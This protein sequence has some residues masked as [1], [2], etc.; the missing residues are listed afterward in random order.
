MRQ[1]SFFDT[2]WL[3]WLHQ[4]LRS[5]LVVDNKKSV[6]ISLWGGNSPYR[7]E[8]RLA[9]ATECRGNSKPNDTLIAY[10]QV[11]GKKVMGFADVNHPARRRPRKIIG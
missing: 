10:V 2:R 5:F 11:V 1:T 7:Y 3:Q 8:S 4:T 6:E 9:W